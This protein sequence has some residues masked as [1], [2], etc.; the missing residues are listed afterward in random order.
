MDARLTPPEFM[1]SWISVERVEDIIPALSGV[2]PAEPIPESV[3]LR[4]T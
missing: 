4:M 1:A 3:V 2:A